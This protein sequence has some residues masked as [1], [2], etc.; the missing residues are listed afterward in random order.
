MNNLTYVNHFSYIIYKYINDE[1]KS[2]FLVDKAKEKTR[3]YSY[4]YSRSISR[5]KR[6]MIVIS[7]Y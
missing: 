5:K 2:L 4:I 3:N 1:M 7:S 6:K